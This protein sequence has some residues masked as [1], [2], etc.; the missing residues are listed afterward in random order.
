MNIIIIKILNI[1]LIIVRKIGKC[2]N[3]LYDDKIK[4]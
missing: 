2:D 4:A 3:I 1:Y